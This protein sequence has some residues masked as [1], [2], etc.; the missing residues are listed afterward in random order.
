M[1]ANWNLVIAGVDTAEVALGDN[2]KINLILNRQESTEKNITYLVRDVLHLCI[3]VYVHML[4][5]LSCFLQ[6]V[7]YSTYACRINTH[8]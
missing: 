1:Y 4:E 7:W 2:M 3:C 6:P 8:L 5:Y